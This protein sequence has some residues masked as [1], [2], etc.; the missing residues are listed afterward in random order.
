[1]WLLLSRC[2]AADPKTAAGSKIAVS[3]VYAHLIS[4]TNKYS[5]HRLRVS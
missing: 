4:C 1:M 3:V 2:V 5:W